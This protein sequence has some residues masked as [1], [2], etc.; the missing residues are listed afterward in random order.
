MP[1][2]WHQ[3]EIIR[4]DFLGDSS[5]KSNFPDQEARLTPVKARGITGGFQVLSYPRSILESSAPKSFSAGRPWRWAKSTKTG[6]WCQL[7][8]CCTVIGWLGQDTPSLHKAWDVSNSPCF[9]KV[10]GPIRLLCC[11]ELGGTLGSAVS[12]WA[13]R[14]QTAFSCVS[15]DAAK[16]DSIFFP[17]KE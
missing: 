13:P 6:S 2:P 15:V 16:V 14:F 3:L 10:T 12:T 1:Q 7:V 17:L 5:K 9:H 11:S 4:W 8:S